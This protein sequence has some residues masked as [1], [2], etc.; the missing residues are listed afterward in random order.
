MLQLVLIGLFYFAG[1]IFL[2]DFETKWTELDRA[3][4]L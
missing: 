4:R 3:V 2:T 1:I